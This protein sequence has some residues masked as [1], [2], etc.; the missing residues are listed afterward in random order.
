MK[1]YAFGNPQHGAVLLIHT[2]FTN[3]KFFT[4]AINLLSK[5]Y[6]VIA[7]TLSGHEN[8]EFISTQDEINKIESFLKERGINSLY[9]VA[10]FS[11]GGNIA[12][13]FFC[14]HSDIIERCVIDSAPMFDFPKIIE[15]HFYKDYVGCLKAIKNEGCDVAAELDKHFNGM[16]EYQKEIAPTVSENS[17]KGLVK[18]CFNVKIRKL[19]DTD[20]EKLTFVYGT[21]DAARRCTHRIKKYRIEKMKGYGHCGFYRE[22]PA[23]WVKK[24]IID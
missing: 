15:R 11:L 5:S 6:Y 4:P 17:M 2:L 24:F 23:A 12:Y 8:S 10:G 19:S 14:K 16:G 13:E 20:A 21:K 9:A 7:P 22:N 3:Y 18:S 1:F